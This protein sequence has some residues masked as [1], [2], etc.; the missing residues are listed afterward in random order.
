MVSG[1]RT[2][3][4]DHC[5]ICS[6]EASRMRTALKLLTSS[7]TYPLLIQTASLE[8]GQVDVERRNVVGAHIFQQRDALLVLVQD[9]DREPEALQLLYEHLEGLRHAGLEYV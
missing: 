9:L 3:P 7:T 1:L 6:G 2:S 5:R 8:P 4:R